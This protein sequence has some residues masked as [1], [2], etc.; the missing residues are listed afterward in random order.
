MAKFLR[1]GNTKVY[2]LP[3]IAS[4]TLAPTVAEINAGTLLSIVNGPNELADIDGF[5]RQSNFI[6]TPH[7]GSRQTPKIP[8]EI[9]APDSSLTFYED[10][11]TNPVSTVLPQDQLGFIVLGKSVA[12]AAKVDVFPIQVAAQSPEYSAGNEAAKFKVDIAVTGVPAT[13]IAVL[14]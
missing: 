12:A 14:A 7:F 10:D 6:D 5:R 1:R 11:T 4:T 9:E 13:K 2:F 3:T 8:G